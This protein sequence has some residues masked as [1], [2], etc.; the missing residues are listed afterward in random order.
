MPSGRAGRPGLTPAARAPFP[1]AADRATDARVTR[2]FAFVLPLL[3][4]AGCHRARDDGPIAVSVVGPPPAA[5]VAD[6]DRGPLDPPAAVLALATRQGLLRF[7]AG[8]QIVPGVA[9]RWI[10]TDDGRSLIFRLPGDGDGTTAEAIARRLRAA[11]APDSRNPLKPLLGAITEVD[12]VTPQVIDVEL[13][14]PRPNLLQLFA[15]PALTLAAAGGPFRI[16]GTP[17][18]LTRLRQIVPPAADPDDRPPPAETVLLHADRAATAVARFRAGR[19]ALVLGGSFADLAI[20]RAADP[21][22][23][24]RF[25]PVQGL[26]GLAF[27]AAD[28]GFIADPLR[29]R[30][31]AT[32]IDRDRIARLLDVPGWQ[33]TGTITVAGTPEV[34]QPAIPDWAIGNMAARRASA[35]AAVAGW[36]V[37]GRPP[38]VLRVALPPGPGARLLFA[39][40]ATDWKAIGVEAVSVP[41]GAPADLTLVDEVAPTDSAAFYLRRF[42]CDRGVPCT[43]L[44]DKA[45]IAA[46]EADSLAQRS[47]LLIEADALIAATV[48]YIPLGNPVRWS[49]VAPEL[50]R[51][52]DSPRGL[53][54]LDELRTPPRG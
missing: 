23:R 51:Y 21:G 7:D 41:L 1:V 39:A 16:V 34:P 29:R 9:A 27:A 49:L 38:P 24:L 46:R 5:A 18:G 40:V 3:A 14:A 31:L 13:R 30:A 28:T 20:A 22:P 35:R 12:A 47:Q 54:P 4:A 6:P 26:F 43:E 8:G 19:A 50:D 17:G 2:R 11:I 33:A 42:A 32:A 10:V 53:H 52:R 48:A 37:S 45:L 25:D 44:S 36:A 15:Q